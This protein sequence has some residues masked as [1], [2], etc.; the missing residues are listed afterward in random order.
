MINLRE[1]SVTFRDIQRQTR[2]QLINPLR[3]PTSHLVSLPD[4]IQCL[5]H[6]QR[7]L[8]DIQRLVQ[9][10]LLGVCGICLGLLPD[11]T[12]PKSCAVRPPCEQSAEAPLWPSAP[13]PHQ[14]SR[15]GRPHPDT[16]R[17]PG[18]NPANTQCC[19]PQH[20]W[21]EG[22]RPWPSWSQRSQ[23][24]CQTDH[25]QPMRVTMWRAERPQALQTSKQHRRHQVA[26]AGSSAPFSSTLIFR[27]NLS[28]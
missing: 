12:L 18:Q 17:I 8:I 5:M 24:P 7:A 3:M 15:G 2:R 11:A 6:L 9:E 10:V 28:P 20:R 13:G 25:A 14:P 23:R 22:A 4:R 27:P 16:P 21:H 1:P 19:R 26:H